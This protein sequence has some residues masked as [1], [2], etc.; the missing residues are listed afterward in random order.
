MQV[1][2]YILNHEGT[3]TSKIA[4]ELGGLYGHTGYVVITLEK[5]N[6][7]E[8]KKTIGNKRTRKFELSLTQ[9][10][11]EIAELSRDLL[12]KIKTLKEKE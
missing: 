5:L 4:K 12:N 6:L 7:I 8:K 9:E 10:G 1:L 11:R 3:H 2:E